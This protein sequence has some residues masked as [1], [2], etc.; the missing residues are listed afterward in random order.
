MHSFNRDRNCERQRAQLGRRQSTRLLHRGSGHIDACVRRRS[1]TR[2]HLG[3][4]TQRKFLVGASG[5]RISSRLGPTTASSS[6]ISIGSNED[7][8]CPVTAISD[9]V[10]THSFDRDRNCERQRSQLGRRQTTRLLL[11]GS[12]RIG[13]CVRR[14][15]P[16]RRHHCI[17]AESRSLPGSSGATIRKA[18]RRPASG[19]SFRSSVSAI[20]TRSLRVLPVPSNR[21]P[22]ACN[23]SDGSL[24]GSV[25][26]T[27]WS[28]NKLPNSAFAQLNSVLSQLHVLHQLEA[29]LRFTRGNPSQCTSSY[30]VSVF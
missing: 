30:G 13:A 26:W 14:W 6:L 8:S 4:F 3:G 11:R 24:L 7:F 21:R 25:G 23:A 9:F 1:P 15:S 2:R 27:F 29:V 10:N 20:F 22:G 28:G 17:L 5:S 16:T 12:G 19:N 18:R